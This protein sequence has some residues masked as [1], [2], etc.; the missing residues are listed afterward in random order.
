MK[1]ISYSVLL[2][3]IVILFSS[4]RKDFETIP[5]TGKLEFSKD[6]IYLD[7]VFSTISSSTYALKVYNRSNNDI[8]IPKIQLAKAD[9]K[10][11]MMID[12]MTGVDA[13]NSGIGDGKI[14]NNVTLL[15]NDS[16]YVFIETTAKITDAATDFTYTD[17]ITFDTGTKEQKVELITLI[18]DAKFIFP[19]RPLDTGI[20]ELI[21]VNGF[22]D[23]QGNLSVGHTL[24]GD[25]L[26]WTKE[27]P[28]VI[29]GYAVVPNG[30]TLIIDKG[31]RVYFHY[32]ASLVVDAN[33]KLI[34]NGELNATNTTTGA[35]ITQNE[36]TFEGDRLEPELENVPGQWGTIYLFSGSNENK[37]AHLTL[38]NA[39]VGILMQTNIDNNTPNLEI[40]NS[41]VYG[42]SNYGILARNSKIKGANLVIN[43]AGQAC[44]SCSIGGDY[45]F[46][47]CTF[48]N[49]WNSS[50]QL[51]VVVSNY[52]KLSDN[53]FIKGNLVKANFYNCIIFGINNIE[54]YLDKSDDAG[55]IF[56]TDF[57]NCLVKFRDYGTSLENNPMYQFLT[58]TPNFDN[59][60]RNLDPKFFKPNQNKLNI[61]S[62]SAAFQAGSTSYLVPY[63][64]VNNIRNLNLPDLGAYSNRPFP[65]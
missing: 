22:A 13:D 33:A 57:K 45:D 12:G 56:N 50:K 53:T 64:I 11:R 54:L 58:A 7:T 18:Q 47:H 42:C 19:N 23:D 43:N 1:R 51:A 40:S 6:T 39:T 59:N 63:D 24:K 36:V 41:Q 35:V 61:D 10:Y 65:E 31:T 21:S 28:Y 5:S 4:C 44:L 32:G 30:Q 37:I 14:F 60:I 26:H 20:K 46:K 9:S 17:K 55:V 52:L 29:Y 3:G 8:T 2:I 62:N 48:N 34:I 25:E 38:K 49:N 15:A 16:L 27:K